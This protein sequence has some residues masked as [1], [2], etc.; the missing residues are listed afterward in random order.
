MAE[1]SLHTSL[2]PGAYLTGKTIRGPGLLRRRWVYHSLF[3]LVYC[4]LLTLLYMKLYMV[5]NALFFLEFLGVLALEAAV[6]YSNLYLLIPRL[7]F[8]RKYF[9]YAL[10]LI[11]GIAV[12]IVLT[13]FLN[14]LY[15]FLGSK[16]FAMVAIF[17]I[18]NVAIYFI[19]TFY[20]RQEV[21]R[22]IH[23]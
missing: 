3:W 11:A 23:R 15:A 16:L 21:L 22:R 7:L 20:H 13:I 17:N 19:D 18:H 14:K 10:S 9:Y 2:A 5:Y 8:R 4:L 1:G 12:I 6:V